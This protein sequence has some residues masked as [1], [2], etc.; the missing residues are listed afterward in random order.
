MS[1][2][3]EL[4]GDFVYKLL[5]VANDRAAMAALRRYMATEQAIYACPVVEPILSPELEDWQRKCFYV[6]AG[7][8]GCHPEHTPHGN[9]GNTF[10][11]IATNDSMKKRFSLLLE[12][13]REE[14]Y[15]CL[16]NIIHLIKSKNAPINYVRLLCDLIYWGDSVKQ[17]WAVS[18]YRYEGSDD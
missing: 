16:G 7:L 14:I 3:R 11:R 15:E 10:K 4:A 8:F 1:D 5:G 6:V 17:Q 2:I 9:L 13:D 18:F 12:L